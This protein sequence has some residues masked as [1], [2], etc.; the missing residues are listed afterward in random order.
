MRARHALLYPRPAYNLRSIGAN[1]DVVVNGADAVGDPTRVY[2]L[3]SCSKWVEYQFSDPASLFLCCPDPDDGVPA[4]IVP[5]LTHLLPVSSPGHLWWARTALRV[6][7]SQNDA[8]AIGAANDWCR[9]GFF[10]W[11]L[12]DHFLLPWCL[13]SKVLIYELWLFLQEPREPH[14]YYLINNVPQVSENITG[15][16]HQDMPRICIYNCLHRINDPDRI[17]PVSINRKSCKK[18]SSYFLMKIMN[19]IQG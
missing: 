7:T 6:R 19:L 3:V 16:H 18:K 14:K 2:S 4:F 17:F 10:F 9:W 11:F 8:A 5:P 13:Q 15:C 12:V 1:S